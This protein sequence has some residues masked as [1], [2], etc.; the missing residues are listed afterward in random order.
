MLRLPHSPTTWAFPTLRMRYLHGPPW[1]SPPPL[2]F[3]DIREAT[4]KQ[5]FRHI[6]TL[7]PTRSPLGIIAPGDSTPLDLASLQ[8]GRQVK[9]SRFLSKAGLK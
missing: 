7:S 8:A 6:S 2:G 3:L 4:G 1:P 9:D 5:Y